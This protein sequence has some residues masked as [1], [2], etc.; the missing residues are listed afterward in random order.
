MTADA[1]T[2]T[3]NTDLTSLS[4]GQ[5]NWLIDE[6]G[7]LMEVDSRTYLGL[8][9]SDEHQYE[10]TYFSAAAN[11]YVSNHAFIELDA[12]GDPVLSIF[13]LDEEDDL[14]ED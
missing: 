10:V 1:N 9:A 3:A 5:I 14:F 8:N 7:E 6:A 12:D 13:D 11:T 2:V 4:V